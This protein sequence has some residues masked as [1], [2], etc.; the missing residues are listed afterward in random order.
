MTSLRKLV[1][2]LIVVVVGAGFERIDPDTVG[3]IDRVVVFL[4]GYAFGILT[5]DT[6]PRK[7]IVTPQETE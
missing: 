4:A 7:R 5:C 2:L 1:W 6:P 3:F